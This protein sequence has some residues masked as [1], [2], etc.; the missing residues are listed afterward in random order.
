M[1][2]CCAVRSDQGT[3]AQPLCPALSCF[4]EGILGQ[5]LS[6]LSPGLSSSPR[7]AQSWALCVSRVSPTGC[8][9]PSAQP[10]RAAELGAA[11][12]LPGQ[13]KARAQPQPCCRG[14]TWG[15]LA[16]RSKQ[17][18]LHVLGVT[19]R[20]N[21][22]LKGALK[23][24]INLIFCPGCCRGGCGGLLAG[25]ET[26]PFHSLQRRAGRFPNGI[27]SIENGDVTKITPFPCK[28]NFI[29]V[30]V[31]SRHRASLCPASSAPCPCEPG[32]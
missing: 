7:A 11:S 29:K 17:R 2:T 24:P 31:G 19:H 32:G 14:S 30:L 10:G 21:L 4:G 9:H 25:K 15:E 22:C 28:D 16:A 23:C 8:A 20:D 1:L 27:F 3:E 6:S 5:N 12:V 18:V 26:P 13:L